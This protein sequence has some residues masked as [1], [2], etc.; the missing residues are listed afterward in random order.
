MRTMRTM[1]TMRVECARVDLHAPAGVILHAVDH[2][3]QLLLAAASDDSMT[4]QR[5]RCTLRGGQMWTVFGNTAV[6]CRRLTASDNSMTTQRR[7]GTLRGGQMWT[8]FET[9]LLF[10]GG[11][12][13]NDSMTQ[14]QRC[15]LASS[16][17][18]LFSNKMALD[19]LGLWCN[20]WRSLH[21]TLE[22]LAGLALGDTIPIATRRKLLSKLAL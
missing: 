5:R 22:G 15:T 9:Q 16:K 18:G 21:S 14:R 8:V 1:R 6:V 12:Q 7:R 20:R 11:R 10:V 13:R 2:L 4:T 17:R 19:H 3:I